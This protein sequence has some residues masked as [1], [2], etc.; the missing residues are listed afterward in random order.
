MRGRE[1]QTE[2]GERTTALCGPLALSV[3]AVR[4]N[5]EMQRG[6]ERGTE[7]LT[8]W[9]TAVVE[10]RKHGQ[11]ERQR[12]GGRERETEGWRTGSGVAS[13]AMGR[14]R[15]RARES[16]IEAAAST[17]CAGCASAADGWWLSYTVCFIYYTVRA[18]VSVVRARS[19]RVVES[20][21]DAS[22]NLEL[23]TCDKPARIRA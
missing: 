17:V 23:T 13:R 20:A 22:I 1:K 18:R 14:V 4:R 5:T 16:Q 2:E 9:M 11:R 3:C 10:R 7:E 12:E 8:I 6:K 15:A 21:A 19:D